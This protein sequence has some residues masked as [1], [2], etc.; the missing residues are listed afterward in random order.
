MT[1]KSKSI[2]KIISTVLLIALLGGAIYFA[3][4]KTDNFSSSVYSVKFN[5]K[6]V[7][8]NTKIS[9]T[10]DLKFSVNSLFSSVIKD[11]K[12]TVA[13][14]P[15]YDFLYTVDGENKHFSDLGDISSALTITTDGNTFT[16]AKATLTDVMKILYPNNT[17]ALP[18]AIPDYA[19]LLIVTLP[20][21]TISIPFNIPN[22]T[23]EPDKDKDTDGEAE[24]TGVILDKSTIVY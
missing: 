8:G 24:V 11:T 9:L 6:P 19:F 15:A 3:A 21:E 12:Y 18:T 1:K 10:D 14:K 17:V 2:V 13:V 16:I 20:T 7:D 22:N 23:T 5:E 4:K